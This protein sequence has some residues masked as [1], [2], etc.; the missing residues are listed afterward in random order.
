MTTD[1]LDHTPDAPSDVFTSMLVAAILSSTFENGWAGLSFGQGMDRLT[2]SD[3]S[4]L[5]GQSVTGIL[6]AQFINGFVNSSLA[7]YTVALR[8]R[9]S[10]YCRR[11]VLTELTT[12]LRTLNVLSSS[13]LGW[14]GGHSVPKHCFS[15][16]SINRLLNGDRACRYGYRSQ[17]LASH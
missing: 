3:G 11:E 5:L 6:A 16:E 14:H 2:A 8:H 12:H 1:L 17:R 4:I 13:A 7:N 9:T 15:A 10:S